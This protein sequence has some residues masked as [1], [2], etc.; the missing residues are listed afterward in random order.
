MEIKN[1]FL[2]VVTLGS[3]NPAILTPEFLRTE[4]IWFSEEHMPKGTSSPV[5]S[6]I[7]FGDIS[8]FVELE[9]FQVMHKNV[10]RLNDSPL[11]EA[12]SKYLNTLRYTPVLLQGINFNVDIIGY[13]NSKEIKVLLEDPINKISDYFDEAEEYLLDLRT[14]IRNGKSDNQSINCKFYIS[15]GISISINLRKADANLVLNYNYEVKDIKSDNT[16]LDLIPNGYNSIYEN[17]MQFIKRLR[18]E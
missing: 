13:G 12:A 7:K 16:R 3:F 10:K 14:A 4:G 15:P 6:D 1:N 5:V 18:G 9:R 2:S 11:V 17:F 8:F